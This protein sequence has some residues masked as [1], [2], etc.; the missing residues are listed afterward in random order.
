MAATRC[1]NCGQKPKVLRLPRG[2]GMRARTIE[3]DACIARL[4]L[5]LNRHGF[6]TAASC[7]GHGHR[8]GNIAL[9]DGRELIIAPDFET[10]RAIDRLFP[11]DINGSPMEGN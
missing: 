9:H 3:I 4:V 10:G 5:L 1:R 2:R 11:L 8:P 6:E 7:C